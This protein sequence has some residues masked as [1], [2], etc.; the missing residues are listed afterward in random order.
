MYFSSLFCVLHILPIIK[1]FLTM[2]S[3]QDST[4]SRLRPE[5]LL[6]SLG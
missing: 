5:I 1:M 6:S 3:F 2:Q 4:S